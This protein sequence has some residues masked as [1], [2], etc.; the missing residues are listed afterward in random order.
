MYYTACLPYYIYICYEHRYVSIHIH[1][2]I[3][4]CLFHNTY[5][6]KILHELSAV[7]Q[8]MY[9]FW[10]KVKQCLYLIWTAFSVC[11]HD[12]ILLEIPKNYITSRMNWNFLYC[13]DISILNTPNTVLYTYICSQYSLML[14]WQIYILSIHIYVIIYMSW[15]YLHISQLLT[16][17]IC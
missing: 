9:L 17:I 11:T 13:I 14:M 8:Y 6:C 16:S 4:M 15:S 3:T 12:H 10:K 1:I 5:T 2:L 7:Y